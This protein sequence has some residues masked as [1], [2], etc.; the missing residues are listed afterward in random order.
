MLW[1]WTSTLIFPGAISKS[2]RASITSSPLFM[3]VAESIVIFLPMLQFG[4]LSACASVTF[5]RSFFAE[6]RKGP[7]EAVKIS[8]LISALAP[9][10]RHWKMALCSL[11]TG[12]MLNAA[13]PALGHDQL[14]RGHEHFLV[15]KRDVLP[16]RMAAMVGT[17]PAVPTMA[18][19]VIS[20]S[21]AAATW[22]MPSTPEKMRTLRSRH[23]FFSSAA[24]RSL[25]TDTIDGLNCR[26]CFS[27]NSTLFPA[28]SATTV[29]R[30]GNFST[31]ESVDWPIEPVEPSMD[32]F[33]NLSRT[34][35]RAPSPY[36]RI[37]R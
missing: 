11:S 29:K 30:S 18:E 7:P 10:C 27:N 13:C 5:A 14:A 33:F 24:E 25:T 2:H 3:S 31:T 37:L 8:S 9:A 16:A 15:R 28:A 17:S 21:S 6:A 35:T 36:P 23:R 19:T 26:T 32:I 20:A 22:I 1:G 34:G 12:R 4:C